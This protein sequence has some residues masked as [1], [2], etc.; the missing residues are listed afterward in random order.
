MPRLSSS[1]SPHL[2][3]FVTDIRQAAVDRDEVAGV[4]IERVRLPAG[5]DEFLCLR[6]VILNYD[7]LTH[8]PRPTGVLQSHVIGALV[9]SA[10]SVEA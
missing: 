10:V 9:E 5:V 6:V 3:P 1:R 4:L 2:T 8:L 7:R